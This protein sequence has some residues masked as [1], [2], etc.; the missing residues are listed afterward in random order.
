M[1]PRPYLS[2]R[3][4]RKVADDAG[5][6]CGYCLS[7][8]R[9]VGTIMDIEHIIPISLGGA[10][11]EDNLWLACSAC[12][13]HKSD[14]ITAYDPESGEDVLIYNPR[15]QRWTEHFKWSEDGTTIVGLTPMGR[16][17]IIILHMNRAELVIARGY[18]VSAGW[19]PPN[20]L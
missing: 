9:I 3:L 5:H 17:T 4:R 10:T 13:G 18:W 7:H 20:D 16:A 8:E 6:R 2:R 12:N 14:R 19:H 15:L 11:E 1:T